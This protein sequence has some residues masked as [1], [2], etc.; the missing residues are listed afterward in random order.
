MCVRVHACG[1]YVNV[2]LYIGM[3]VRTVLQALPF[4]P[5]RRG[6]SRILA[7][8]RGYLRAVVIALYHHVVCM[9]ALYLAKTQMPKEKDRKK[10]HKSQLVALAVSFRLCAPPPCDTVHCCTLQLRKLTLQQDEE[11]FGSIASQLASVPRGAP[12]RE[13]V[14]AGLAREEEEDELEEEERQIQEDRHCLDLLL[15]LHQA[16]MWHATRFSGNP[17]MMQLLEITTLT[18]G[19]SMGTAMQSCLL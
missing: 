1:R 11:Q 15:Q 6:S 8:N 7:T 14:V 13:L 12:I 19:V 2:R 18:L 9:C 3:H 5:K 4:F 17:D 16:F 10:A